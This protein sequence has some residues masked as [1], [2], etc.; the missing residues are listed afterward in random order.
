M[1]GWVGTPLAALKPESVT[2]PATGSRGGFGAILL[3]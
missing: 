1:T 3:Q 2:R